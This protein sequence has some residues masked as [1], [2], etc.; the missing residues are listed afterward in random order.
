MSLK[1]MYSPTPSLSASCLAIHQRGLLLA[2]RRDDRL[3]KR[4]PALPSPAHV[5]VV[6]A[7]EE[8][9]VREDHVGVAGDL[10]RVRVHHH[11]QVE[12]RDRLDRLLLVGQR[13]QQVRGVHD[14]ALDRVGLAADRGLAQARRHFLVRERPL[15]VGVV[16]LRLP[17]LG[18][19]REGVARELHAGLEEEPALAAPVAQERVEEGRGARALR[20]VAVP[21]DA[22]ARVHEGGGPRLAISR[23]VARIDAAG[24]PVSA[25][26]HSGVLSLIAATNLSKPWPYFATNSLS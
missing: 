9:G 16:D 26:A 5:E 4:R 25:S 22:P 7:L 17:G 10:A 8:H 3:A 21:V 11:Q 15:A 2:R 6:V 13:L 18:K 1:G 14:P 23:A 20:V 24:M 19:L 12:L